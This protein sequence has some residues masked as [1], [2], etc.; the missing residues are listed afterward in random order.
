MK[1]QIAI[2][3]LGGQGVLFITRLL[4]ETALTLDLP[5]MSSET[6]GMAVRG[7]AVVSHLKVGGFHSPLIRAGQA[8]LAF[9]LA[10]ENL[11]VH[12]FLIGPNTRVYV[13]SAAQGDHVRFDASGAAETQL[14]RRQAENLVLLGYALGQGAL[15]GRLETVRDVLWANSRNATLAD[16]NI[17]ALSV[18]FEAAG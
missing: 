9:F 10:D 7:G 11:D 17:N 8:D 1:Q 14:G 15:F 13:N 12:P 3:G 4:A 18:G 5:V 2:S 16:A 6:H